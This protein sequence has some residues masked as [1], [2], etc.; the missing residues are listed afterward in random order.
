MQMPSHRSLPRPLRGY[1]ICSLFIVSLLTVCAPVTARGQDREESWYLN[2]YF[3][4]ITPDKP[5]GGKGSSALYGLDVGMYLSQAWSIELDLND[6]PLSDRFGSGPIHL[7]GSALGLLRVFTVNR[8]FAP[9]VSIGMGATHLAPPAGI[10]LESRTEFMAQPGAGAFVNVWESRN[11]SRSVA[12]RP[13][14][15]LR[16]T[17][18][19]AHAPGNPVDPLYV[20]GLTLAF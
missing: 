20:L 19:W 9:Y 8:A 13:D 18:G 2:S 17:H 4:G 3:G 10:G 11:H 12:L 6:A 14:I 5:W 15:K 1:R 7:Y 16:W